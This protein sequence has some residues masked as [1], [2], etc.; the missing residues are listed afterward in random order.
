VYSCLHQHGLR[1]KV[2]ES[3][4]AVQGN[5]RTDDNEVRR[6]LMPDLAILSNNIDILAFDLDRLLYR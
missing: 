2:S 1:R 4:L 6:V 3:P 5:A